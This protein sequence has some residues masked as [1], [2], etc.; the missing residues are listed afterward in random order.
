M[1]YLTSKD[2]LNI[3]FRVL[4]LHYILIEKEKDLKSTPPSIRDYISLPKLSSDVCFY[5]PFCP[6]KFAMIFSICDNTVFGGWS[7]YII[8]SPI[9]LKI[10]FMFNKIVI[11]INYLNFD[12]EIILWRMDT[13][14]GFEVYMFC[15]FN[16]PTIYDLSN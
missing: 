4:K 16:F 15:H 6:E 12:I 1:Q 2:S 14:L 13:Y 9:Q 5:P 3:V 8:F 7:T 10:Y 11:M